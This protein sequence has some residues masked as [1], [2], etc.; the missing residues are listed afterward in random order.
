MTDMNKLW[1]IKDYVTV[2]RN[3]CFIQDDNNV[4]WLL[5]EHVFMND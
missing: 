2:K 4:I 1:N 5:P 3:Q